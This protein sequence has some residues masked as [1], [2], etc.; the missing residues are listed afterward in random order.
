MQ[1]EKQNKIISWQEK[2]HSLNELPGEGKPDTNAAWEKLQQRLQPKSRRKGGWFWLAA[3][4]ILL[5]LMIPWAITKTNRSV[6]GTNADNK[7][8]PVLPAISPERTPG[9]IVSDDLKDKTKLP[10]KNIKTAQAKNNHTINISPAQ[11]NPIATANDNNVLND[12]LV[13]AENTS[14]KP[15]SFIATTQKINTKQKL[16]VVHINELETTPALNPGE[17]VTSPSNHSNKFKINFLHDA[18]FGTNNSNAADDAA[19]KIF[20]NN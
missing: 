16:R 20:I 4:C 1:E 3:A 15:D 17:M 11:K 19:I 7:I 5:T 6:D 18:Q 8:Q 9:I 12:E 13:T 14:V 10:D 2:L